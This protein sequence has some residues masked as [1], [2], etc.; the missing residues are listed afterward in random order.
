M[1]R[2]VQ[3]PSEMPPYYL[4]VLRVTPADEQGLATTDER[5]DRIY[6]HT[7][8][9]YL[10]AYGGAVATHTERHA[11]PE[12][13]PGW[14]PDAYQVGL[15]MGRPALVHWGEPLTW[16][17]GGRLESGHTGLNVHDWRGRS[18]GCITP[19]GWWVDA[20]LAVC[21]SAGVGSSSSRL[22]LLMEW[23]PGV[24]P[25]VARAA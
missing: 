20:A 22:G 4:R 14:Y 10:F 7:P 9:G 24:R 21:E 6:L 18:D 11:A 25:D 13:L 17:R 3:L 12:I 23:G 15:H 8:D 1:T 2:L 5:R 16:E 19:P